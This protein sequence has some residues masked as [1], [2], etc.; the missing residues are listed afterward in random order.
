M[1]DAVLFAQGR[2]LGDGVLFLALTVGG[3][4]HGGVQHLAGAVDDRHLAAVGIAGVQAHGDVALHRRLHQKGLQVQG[5][6]ADG[7]FV[8]AVGEVGT[9]LPLQRGVDEPVVGVLA[10]G[11]D[12]RRRRCAGLDHCRAQ[13]VQRRLPIQ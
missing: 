3:I 2:Q 9:G 6:L 10:G 12:E 4:D 1:G 13:R 7:T 8:G 11:A 5:E